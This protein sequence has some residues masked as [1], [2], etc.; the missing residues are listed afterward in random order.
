[1]LTLDCCPVT[2]FQVLITRYDKEASVREW[3]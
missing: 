1:M 3:D 2:P